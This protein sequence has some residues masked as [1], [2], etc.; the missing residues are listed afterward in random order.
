MLVAIP[1]MEDRGLD[2]RISNHFGRAPFFTFV[3]IEDKTVK[4]VRTERN[5]I[6]DHKPG[7]IPR[8]LMRRGVEVVV[9]D[10]IGEKAIRH[11][12]DMGVRIVK[13][14]TGTVR[15]A[16]VKHLKVEISGEEE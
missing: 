8:Y 13:G 11:F 12:E 5:T 9:V 6:V 10:G 1:T 4:R 7:D 16:L 14:V 3:E 2:S 15:E